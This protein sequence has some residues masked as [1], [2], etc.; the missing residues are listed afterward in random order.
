MFLHRPCL[1]GNVS[2]QGGGIAGSTVRQV[3]QSRKPTTKN[4]C[5]AELFIS[6]PVASLGTY[7]VLRLIWLVFKF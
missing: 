3:G 5:K 2:V 4:R 7:T 1:C 6:I